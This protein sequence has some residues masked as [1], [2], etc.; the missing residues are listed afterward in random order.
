MELT[1]FIPVRY[2]SLDT[3]R[4]RLDADANA[5]IPPTDDRFMDLTPGGWYWDLTNVFALEC[6]RMW[7]FLATEVVAAIFPSFSWGDYLDE[8][9]VTLNLPRKPASQATGTLYL[10]GDVGTTVPAGTVV[11]VPQLDP[12]ATPVLFQTMTDIL[13]AAL[14]APVGL[15][16]S[17]VSSGGTLDVVNTIN[18]L[19]YWYYV[20]TAVTL[21]GETIAS[22][23]VAIQT[24]GHTS[25][26][27][28]T[29]DPVDQA[30]GYH[31]Y[32]GVRSGYCYHLMMLG[33]VTTWVDDGSATLGLSPPP[34]NTVAIQAVEAAE[35]GNVPIATVTELMSPVVGV[36]DVTNPTATSGGADVE[37]D[38]AYRTR[39]L[40]ALG[41]PQGGGTQADY[42][43]W[44][45]SYPSVGYA[46]VTPIWSGPG[47]VKATVTDP[48]N[49]PV[50]ATVLSQIQMDLDPVPQKGEG[51]API[52]AAVTIDTP[53]SIAVDVAATLTLADGYS[54]D[55]LD[56]TIAVRQD[57]DDAIATYINALP[58]GGDVIYEHA[59][60]T[61]FAVDGVVDVSGFT[62]NGGTANV[63]MSAAQVAAVGEPISLS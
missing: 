5:G 49:N 20:V 58:P 32:R 42:E 31:V 17:Q 62:L 45:L 27:T 33:E 59:K 41:E 54:L 6:E 19:G 36:S 40:I 44:T 11:G 13:L 2:E 8:W 57:V 1:D 18:G 35:I 43:T 29:W 60:S 50:S 7:N 51:I 14:P 26:V 15:G 21:E 52:G 25:K 30:L 9:G 12:N 48:D 23:E 61:V 22:N 28:L 63:V 56:G 37:T 10:D 16:A 46:T 34:T 38:E 53:V 4:A 55:G 3:I 39:I 47:T 24:V